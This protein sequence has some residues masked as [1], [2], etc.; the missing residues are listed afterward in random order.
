MGGCNLAWIFD[1]KPADAVLISCDIR[2]NPMS[3]S[4]SS[5]AFSCRF[6][7]RCFK[8][9]TGLAFLSELVRC[10]WRLVVKGVG[11]RSIINQCPCWVFSP[12]IGEYS[13]SPQPFVVLQ[14]ISPRVLFFFSVLL[15]F[16]RAHFASRN[17]L[18]DDYSALVC[19]CLL[20]GFDSSL[21]TSITVGK[22]GFCQW[23]TWHPST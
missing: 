19:Q 23:G 20:K 1:G 14:F 5:W 18:P 15:S 12:C 2:C 9:L 22:S 6:F 11:K 3:W 16:L 21:K 13:G 10:R 17:H 7:C 8:Q 4:I